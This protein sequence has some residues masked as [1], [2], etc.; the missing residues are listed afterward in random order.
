MTPD[1]GCFAAI[2]PATDSEIGWVPES[3]CD[4]VDSAVNAASSAFLT[5]AATPPLERSMI[6][7]QAVS[8]LAERSADI[9]A[10]ISLE[11]GRPFR[12]E[13]QP[14]VA[15]AIRIFRYFSGLPAE[16]KGDT[17]LYAPSV[18]AFTVR[19]PLG[20]VGAIVPWNVPAMLFCLKVAPALATGNTVV[21][22]PAEQ[23][24]LSTMLIAQTLCEELPDGVVNVVNGHG[25]IAGRALSRHPKVVKLT[26]T[27]SVA[28]G[29]EI[30]KESAEKLIPATL[31]LGG[32][33]PI[34]V[35]PDVNIPDA[36]QQTITGMRF[37]RQGQSC[38]S[39][40]RILVH[41]TIREAFV[42]ALADGVAE[43]TI[44]DPLDD[45]TDI[46]TL[47]SRE[48][49]RR[50]CEYLQ[51]ARDDQLEIIELNAIPLLPNLV[52]DCFVPAT[53]IMDPPSDSR[54]VQ[55]E[56]F[57]PV[58]TVH[59]WETFDE[60]VALANGTEF[61]LSACILTD[62]S[63]QGLTMA[64]RLAAGFVQINSGMVIQPG[65]SFGGYRSSGLG[66]EASLDSM[67]EA[68]T[69]VKTVII[70]HSLVGG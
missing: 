66:R 20:V 52:R 16:V 21:V 35:F 41:A 23:A 61:G 29:R 15:N 59:S 28:V 1:H 30:Y 4:D 14:E 50:V 43:L 58:A 24:A 65:L 10:L 46:G 56:I 19:E 62:S 55:E 40:T 51:L 48:Q 64:R 69:Q 53:L 70:D 44:G 31:E 26:F 68:Y 25:D 38:T 36:V 49:V 8:T 39:T 57:G 11:T 17:F 18:L 67:L 5:W 3:T 42:K 45:A 6:L 32:K 47:V 63:S 33:S 34:I 12:T 60:A 7:L 9:A 13:T 2:D 27:G 22:K 54:V 37:S